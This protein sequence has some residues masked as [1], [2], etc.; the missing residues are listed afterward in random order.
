MKLTQ[1][2]CFTAIA[3]HGMNLTRAAHHLHATQPGVTKLIHQLEQELGTE[4][5]VRQRN[6]FTGLSA[7]GECLLP[8]ALRAVDAAD[9]VVRTARSFRTAQAQVLAIAASPTPARW[10]LPPIVQRFSHRYPQTRLR[11]LEGN[12]SH[13]IDCLSR[14][15]ADLCL[16]SPPPVPSPKLVFSPCYELH[17]LLLRRAVIR[18][19]A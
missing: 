8:I 18:S 5:F 7:A 4:L 15:D 11:I 6:R 13:S 19:R 10:F 2:R 3:R 12:S 1:L 17:R 9:E 16:S 14:G